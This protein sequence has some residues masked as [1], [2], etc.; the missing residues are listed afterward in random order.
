MNGSVNL[1]GD[2]I[3]L[4]SLFLQH[5]ETGFTATGP[6]T[7]YG[8]QAEA[9]LNLYR[10]GTAPKDGRSFDLVL[11]ADN[12][13]FKRETITQ[14]WSEPPDV[15]LDTLTNGPLGPL[16]AAALSDGKQREPGSQ[17]E[18]RFPCATH[19]PGL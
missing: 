5:N 10:N 8:V 13:E 11:T 3:V 14:M 4:S 7:F 16:T 18:T 19:M 6:A 12:V 2:S 9:L 17:Q 15:V 1:Y